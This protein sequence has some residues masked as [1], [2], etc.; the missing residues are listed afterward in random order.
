M[1]RALN[2]AATGMAAQQTNVDVIANNLANVNT[3]GFRRSRAEFQDLIYQTL[4]APGGA[5][6]DGQ[7]MPTGLQIGQGVR[8]VATAQVHLQ[9]SLSQT[10]GA[11]DVAIEGAGFLQVTRPNG[12][13]AY[14]RAGDLKSDADGRLVT[15]DGNAVEP[16]ITIPTDATSVTISASGIVSVTQPGSTS[17]QEVGQ[18]TLAS[19][20]NPAGLM[21]IGRSMFVA[22]DASGQAIQGRPGEGGLGTLSQGFLEGSNVEVVNEMIDL[23]A[24]QR[25][26]EINQKVITASDEMLQR[27]AQR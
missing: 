10:G 27:V 8:T 13:I 16:A 11:L 4:R 21:E 5:S 22:T 2:T 26:Y 24:S 19:F 20:A 12:E 1:M 23:I 6:G 25:A 3:T 14:T 9:G 15:V 18:L 7:R 17:S